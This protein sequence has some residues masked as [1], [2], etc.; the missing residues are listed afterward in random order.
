VIVLLFLFLS[1]IEDTGYMARIAYIADRTF[2]SAGLSGRA[3][4]PMLTGFG[5]TVPAVM[6]CRTL[7]SKREKLT[8]MR[9]LPFL[10]CPAKVPV[11]ALLCGVFFPEHTAFAIIVIYLSGV[12]FAS[13]HAVFLKHRSKE[14]PPVFVM[15]L[16]PYRFPTVKNT[17]RLMANKSKEFIKQPLTVILF[18]SVAVWLLSSYDFSLMPCAC[19]DSMLCSIGRF[20]APLFSPLGFGSW[21]AA[22]SLM[23][24]LAAKETIVSTLSLISEG[25]IAEVFTPLSAVSFMTFTLLYT[26]CAASLACMKKETGSGLFALSVGVFQFIIA[27]IM[28]FLV[29]FLG[30]LL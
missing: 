18:A 24:G 27:W 20:I 22:S 23:T 13:V 3:V 5:C 1:I 4:V 6:A 21:K 16:P 17:L 26:P 19:G 7:G 2:S 10:S 11:Y 12:L 30:R 9:L 29:Y 8:V 15:E 25:G 14:K 28:S